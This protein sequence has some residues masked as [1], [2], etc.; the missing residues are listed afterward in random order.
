MHQQGFEISG[1]VRW[2][3]R[4]ID[5][6]SNFHRQIDESARFSIWLGWAG[7]QN[8]I[9]K[10]LHKQIRELLIMIF[11]FWLAAVGRPS[12]LNWEGCS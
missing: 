10:D 3:G 2:S 1:W 12:N 11:S 5:I 8:W 9:G 7:R 6:R 4:Q